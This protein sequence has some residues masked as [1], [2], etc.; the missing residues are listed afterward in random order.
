MYYAN[1]GC[2]AYG[3]MMKGGAGLKEDQFMRSTNR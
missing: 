1:R 3:W 2:T